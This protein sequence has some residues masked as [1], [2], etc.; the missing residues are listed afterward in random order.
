LP[1][2]GGD[3]GLR[4]AGDADSRSWVALSGSSIRD[5]VGLTKRI[6]RTVFQFVQGSKKPWMQGRNRSFQLG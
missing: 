6:F 5:L 2:K 3:W 4:G 1:L